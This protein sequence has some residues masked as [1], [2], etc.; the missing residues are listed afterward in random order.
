[1]GTTPGERFGGFG[2]AAIQFLADLAANN[3][4][5]WF[6]PRKA[7]YE[8][9]LKDPLAALVAALAE[10]FTERGMPLLADPA[11]S[12]FRIYRDVRFA[13]D[14]SPYKANVGA[15]FPWIEGRSQAVG[16]QSDEG[17]RRHAVGGYFHLQPGEIFV[18]GG[19]W[20]P[21]PVPLGA[22]RAAVIGD[23]G[24]V[25]EA[26]DDPTFVATFG[27]IGGD[28]LKRVPPGYPADHPDGELLKLKDVV[29]GRRL[30]DAEVASPELPDLLADAFRDALP[31]LRF[32]ASLPA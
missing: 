11:R 2:P 5:A 28:R 30:S 26:L 4:R 29:F 22:F 20:H 25:R 27:Q 3:D 12:P 1:M 31:V 17:E 24:R 19:M 9:L 6:N 21:G 18:G 8:R 23:R 7:D 10:R 13:R 16:G 15:S 14:K 32:L